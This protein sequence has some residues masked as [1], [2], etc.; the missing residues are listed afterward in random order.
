MVSSGLLRRVALVRI[1]TA[2]KTS[3]LTSSIETGR[4]NVGRRTNYYVIHYYQ[5]TLSIAQIEE[6]NLGMSEIT[7]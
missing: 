7:G 3:N 5:E 1:V 2:V 4:D 6:R